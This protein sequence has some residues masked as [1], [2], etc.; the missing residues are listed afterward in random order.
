MKS[1]E[2]DE[3]P[4]ADVHTSNETTNNKSG[5]AM[6]GPMSKQKND[7][8][9]KGKP[10]AK[11]TTGTQVK[12]K[13]GTTGSRQP[14]SSRPSSSQP[15]RVANAVTKKSNDQEQ[16]ASSKT[17]R[18]GMS[19]HDKIMEKKMA[20]RSKALKENVASPS[21]AGGNGNQP[22]HVEKSGSIKAL[23]T[24]KAVPKVKAP[25]QHCSTSAAS[26][27]PTA[28]AAVKLPAERPVKPQRS[29][30]SRPN[31][32]TAESSRPSASTVRK[33][34]MSKPPSE[35][36]T[37]ARTSKPGVLLAGAKP[38]KLSAASSRKD[39]T[40]SSSQ[41]K[42]I[43]SLEV[44]KTSNV[45]RS[46]KTKL[47]PTEA[48]AEAKHL[49]ARLK[50]KTPVK[51]G[52]G[53]QSDASVSKGS[54]GTVLQSTKTSKAVE[55][56]RLSNRRSST[57]R[58]SLSENV[59]KQK[60]LESQLETAA[61]VK[62]KEAAP[63]LL[64]A[65]ST[66]DVSRDPDSCLSIKNMSLPQEVEEAPCL[67]QAD[68]PSPAENEVMNGE[69]EASVCMGTLD[70]MEKVAQ[71]GPVESSGQL[72]EVEMNPD[73]M[74]ELELCL[75][76]NDEIE[77]I[78]DIVGSEHDVAKVINT[79]H[80][81]NIEAQQIN[82]DENVT[83]VGEVNLNNDDLEVHVLPS[84]QICEKVSILPCSEGILSNVDLGALN[85]TLG[86]PSENV[87]AIKDHVVR[88]P[89]LEDL[90]EPKEPALR[91]SLEDESSPESN[92]NLANAEKVKLSMY[93]Y[94]EE[95]DTEE[96]PPDE[97]YPERCSNHDQDV[98]FKP[99]NLLVESCRVPKQLEHPV[100]SENLSSGRKLG[101]SPEDLHEDQGVSRSSTLSGP[102]LAGKSS[103]VTS[104]PEELKDYNSSSGVESKSEKL[105]S[106][107]NCIPQRD[108][109]RQLDLVEQDLGIHLERGDYEPETLQ[110]MIFLKVLQLSPLCLQRMKII[111]RVILKMWLGKPT[112]KGWKGLITLYLRTKLQMN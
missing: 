27:K 103:S 83:G 36:L 86:S 38:E 23:P 26:K 51:S 111:L 100:E 50:V 88:A 15:S 101:I 30:V 94:S 109:L 90:G 78:G 82:I 63:T 3:S 67:S 32:T 42:K 72:N 41:P 70:E 61:E 25:V 56:Q 75:D 62:R 74:F 45:A 22:N 58:K 55:K 110:Q 93:E 57:S 37:S 4:A 106:A 91:S 107:D 6:K 68:E 89:T 44:S 33:Q 39:L 53:V 11:S 9:A 7:G 105:E 35:H 16:K 21:S 80:L 13:V 95:A 73:Q 54:V 40:L 12:A 28:V 47:K 48:S 104:T 60:S 2:L 76:Y 14:I 1:E 69:P 18:S 20:A 17:A 46:T 43:P 98:V 10:S 92:S 66:E 108:E 64:V 97:L 49:D 19:S 8:P 52:R 31:S 85:P 71:L 102:D 65:P 77:N 34:P 79:T 87:T 84:K 29:T 59:G 81:N 24:S 99:C 112:N 96:S 5:A